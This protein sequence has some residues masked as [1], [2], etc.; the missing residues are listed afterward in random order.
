MWD[1]WVELSSLG[2]VTCLARGNIGEIV[3]V[4]EGADLSLKIIDECS[5]VAAASGFASSEKLLSSHR[6]AMTAQGSSLTSSM[7]RDLSKGG[8][9]EVDQI[10]GD[11][12]ERG[13]RTGVNTPLLE[14]AFVD[15]RVYQ[16]RLTQKRDTRHS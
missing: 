10:L 3:A 16:A 12:L 7:Y 15:L 13:R 9:V 2:A 6:M 5:A 11:L 1:K 4:P 8:R 14:A